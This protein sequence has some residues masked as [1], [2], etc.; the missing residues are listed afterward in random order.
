MTGTSFVLRGLWFF[1]SS[2]AGVI[3]GT[4]LGVMVLLGALIA[5]DSVKE[6]LRQTAVARLGKVD[7]VLSGG[8][9]LFRSALA[10]DLAADGLAAAPVL[11]MNAVVAVPRNGRSLAAVQVIGVD[12]RFFQL[13]PAAGGAEAPVDR[14]IF[15]N[16]HLARSLDLGP[17]E[18]LVLRF[19]KPSAMAGDVPLAGNAAEL[20]VLR[21]EVTKVC[22]DAHFGRFSLATSQLPQAT[23]F[24]PLERLQE[25]VEQ[26]G[27]ANLLL[28]RDP[29]G[30]SPTKLLDNIQARCTLEDYGLSVVDVP[31]AE[32]VE[33]RTTRVFFDRQV[34]AVVQRCWPDARPVITYMANTIAAKGKATP[35]SM[36]TAVDAAAAPFLANMAEG[37]VLNAWEANDLGAG[38]GDEVR[39]DYY[40]LDAANRLVE[41]SATFPVVGIVP[42]S[43]LAADRMWMP[44][45]PGVA[46]AENTSDWD[47]GVPLDMKRIREQ[48]EAY[49][50]AHRGT[51]KVFLP[52]T[53]G[54][55]LFGNRWGQF[56]GLRVPTTVASKEAAAAKLLESMTPAVA[57][58][59]LREVR[60]EGLAAAGSP[61]DFAGLLLGMSIFLMVA[62]VALTAML[63]RF[64]IEQRNRE[65]GLLAAVGI[66]AARLLRWRLG[67]GLGVVVIGSL[68]GVVLALGYTRFL[69][70]WLATIWSDTGEPS[71]MVFHVAPGTVLGGVVGFG[72][73]MMVVI[74][75]GTRKQ[76]R[77]QASLRLEAGAEE[78]RR[79]ATKPRLWV[80]VLLAVTGIAAM[81][82]SGAIGPQ[83]AFFLAGFCFLLA[84]VVTYRWVLQR[85]ATGGTLDTLSDSPIEAAGRMPAPPVVRPFWPRPFYRS[86]LQRR[87]AEGSLDTLSDNPVEAAGRMPAPPVVRPFWPRPLSANATATGPGGQLTAKRLV[88][89]NCGRRATRSLVV[90]G[91]LAAGVF[92]VIS[93]AAF[94]KHGVADWQARQ[95]GTGGYAFWVEITSPAGRSTTDKADDVAGLSEA[96]S[97]FGEV[98]PLRVGTG[99]EANCFNLNTV[100]R[101]R[102]LAT[103]VGALAQRGAFS[104][105]K[106]IPGCEKSWNALR[107]GDVMRAFVDE[108]T[109]LWVLKRKLGERVTYQDEWGRDYPVEIAGTLADSVFQGCFIVDETRFLQ[110]H[111]TAA[112]PRIFLIDKAADLPGGRALLQQTLADRGVTATPTSE[113]LAAFHGVENTYI[114]IFHVLGGLGVILGSAGLGLVTARNLVD[115]RYEFA[116][117][118]TLGIPAAITRRVVLGEVAQLIRWGLGIGLVAAVVAI[119]PTL[120]TAGWA[121][122]LAWIGLLVLGIGLT[123]WGGSWLVFRRR[124]G[125][126]LDARR[127]FG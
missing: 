57:G 36:V 112:A 42:L 114:S 91:S 46:D 107:G 32:A 12:R 49:W 118:H 113:R 43:G 71:R 38:V 67:E 8:D 79:T 76:A 75:W 68:A 31:A 74:W 98:L 64:H 90:V 119:L 110:H 30:R 50:D 117:L 88:E 94:R 21:G 115:R 82:G 81:I 16:E 100:T 59:A 125:T 48:D 13:G 86:V 83:G 123:A 27:K 78:V 96:R 54:R 33:V 23:V 95:S 47:P 73:M 121:W 29:A 85:R 19:S 61:V 51:P 26:P 108:S 99:D 126:A 17:A 63:F 102:L 35:Y 70:A 80:A 18:P 120:A 44:D 25:A 28:L 111:P 24:M 89:L 101:P 62:A 66:P 53:K 10:D 14:G 5:G 105:K 116:I 65:S 37:A 20:Q 87:S 3:A 122:S 58:L 55:E 45:F 97:Q 72:A 34:A 7:A 106:V 109:L 92:L 11:M 1:R 127:E 22:D 69:L 15:V 104:I 52:L 124:L 93:V 77:Q 56:T 2:Y 4:A 84:G 9:R 41:R 103:D 40:A 39:I 6:T 60:L